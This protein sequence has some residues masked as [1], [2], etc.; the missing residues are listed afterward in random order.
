MRK[1]L[2]FILGVGLVSLS[3]LFA[4]PPS[5]E[6][7][8]GGGIRFGDKLEKRLYEQGLLWYVD[9]DE[10]IDEFIWT[11]RDVYTIDEKV[12]LY[13]ERIFVG[14]PRGVYKITVTNPLVEVF[15]VYKVGFGPIPLWSEEFGIYTADGDGYGLPNACEGDYIAKVEEIPLH[16]LHGELMQPKKNFFGDWEIALLP[17]QCYV[18]KIDDLLRLWRDIPEY[19]K[20]YRRRLPKE[21]RGVYRVQWGFSNIIEFEIR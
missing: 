8:S 2:F 21:I 4:E 20:S 5:G 15:T 11:P 16:M 10:S 19:M 12:P 1:F 3:L 17:G 9:G 6:K 7:T 13:I 18:V 14:D